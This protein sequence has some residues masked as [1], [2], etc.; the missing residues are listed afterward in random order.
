VRWALEGLPEGI[1]RLEGPSLG[2]SFAA[3]LLSLFR[4]REA[5]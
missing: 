1:R 5:R 4:D 3:A 2:A